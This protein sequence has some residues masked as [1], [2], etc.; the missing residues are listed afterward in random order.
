MKKIKELK[1]KHHREAGYILVLT[2]QYTD[3]KK[4]SNKLLEDTL[5]IIYHIS[6][7]GR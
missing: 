6:V 7:H 5:S 4:D 2:V 3:K 1:A